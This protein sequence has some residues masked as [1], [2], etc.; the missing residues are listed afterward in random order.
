MG[1]RGTSNC[2]LKIF[3]VT[4]YISKNKNNAIVVGNAVNALTK[5]I[6]G[7]KGDVN[8]VK[9]VPWKIKQ[10]N[11][12]FLKYIKGGKYPEVEV[13]KYIYVVR[14][15]Q[16]IEGRQYVRNQLLIAHDVTWNYW[17]ITLLGQWM[18][19]GEKIIKL[20]NSECIDPIC[21]WWI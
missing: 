1:R 8:K 9:I 11:I 7:I 5:L 20:C 12:D 13:G 19:R 15:G 10:P 3:L 6:H 21:F 14:K 4:L 2:T 17:Y 16:S 18:K